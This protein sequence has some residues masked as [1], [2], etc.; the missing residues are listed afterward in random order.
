MNYFDMKK[1]L[2]S[3][4]RVMRGKIGGGEILD[5]VPKYRLIGMW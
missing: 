4:K 5:L 3:N 1:N 2:K